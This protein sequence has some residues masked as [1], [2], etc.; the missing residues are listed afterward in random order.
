M[1]REFVDTNIL[2]YAFSTD[3]KSA[4]AAS[5]L[6]LNCETSIQGLNEFVSVAR[7]KLGMDW[8]DLDQAL[9]AIQILFRQIHPI[10]NDTHRRAVALARRYDFHIYDALMIS[11]ALASGCETFYSEDL[12]HGM[13][14]E[15]QLEIINPFT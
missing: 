15:K 13:K 4:V 9:N 10:D 11:S 8:N 14:V 3:P 5:I 7:R 6:K 2:V 1:P 12:R